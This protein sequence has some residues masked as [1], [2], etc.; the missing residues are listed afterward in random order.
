MQIVVC[1]KQILDPEL[2]ARDFRIDPERREA[3]KDNLP[4][5][6]NP[7][8]LN[9]VE[10][11]VQLKE[12]HP[13]SKV[14]VITLDEEEAQTGL[15]QALSMGADQAVLVAPERVDSLDPS[16]TAR[17]LAR[18]IAR[19]GTYDLILTGRQAGDW[20]RGLVGL[21]LAEELGLPC[22]PF[23]PRLTIHNGTARVERETPEG[24]AVI[25]TPLPAVVTI[26]NAEDN[27]PRFPKLKDTMMARRKP[28]TRWSI[29]DLGLT[30]DEVGP[31]ARRVEIL[32]L[33]IPSL[34]RECEIIEGETGAEKGQKLMTR[35]Q[36]LKVI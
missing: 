7:F 15:R 28:L 21:L 31:S 20:D 6:V 35:L 27:A 11:A 4:L 2:P 34:E 1:I 12:V 3:V 29:A 24:Y 18:A 30:P 33:A 9:A 17:V 14:T 19:I 23:A 22:V 5:V 8:D 32:D 36:E 25:E 26:T 13:G 16:I 10:V